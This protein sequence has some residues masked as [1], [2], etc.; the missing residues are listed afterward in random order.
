[1]D[2]VDKALENCRAWLSR[3]GKKKSPSLDWEMAIRLWF[4]HKNQKTVARILGTRQGR[5]SAILRRCGVHVGRGKRDP[6]HQLPMEEV[7]R[8]YLAGEST[9]KLGEAFQVDSEVIR[10]R[11]RSA[12]VARRPVGGPKGSRNSQWK[13][14]CEPTVHYYRRQ[15]YEVAAICL[16]QPLPKG[17]VIHHC[18]ENPRNNDPKNLLLFQ[19]PS[20]HAGFHQL[21]LARQQTDPEVD[22]TRLALENGAQA[23]P[24]PPS[25]ILLPPDTT[26]LVPSGKPRLPIW[27]HRKSQQNQD[28]PDPQPESPR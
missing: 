14:G 17:W 26:E 28:K 25:P 3:K 20:A 27:V 18:D 6:I 24:S 12:G 10:R 22:A 9:M 15:A 5:V 16:G 4:Q 11:L 21:L 1:M 8:R 2:T 19:S 13:G 7:A 23:L